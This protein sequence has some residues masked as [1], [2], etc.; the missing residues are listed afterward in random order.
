[1]I[2]FQDENEG[3]NHN[4]KIDNKAFGRVEQFKYLGMI[5]TN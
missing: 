3:K 2:M 4:K 5:L 1:M